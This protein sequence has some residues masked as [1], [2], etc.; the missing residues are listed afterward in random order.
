MSENLG[1]PDNMQIRAYVALDGVHYAILFKDGQI[2]R[3]G[4]TAPD[5]REALANG[6]LVEKGI[7]LRGPF[8]DQS[9]SP[10]TGSLLAVLCCGLGSSWP[11]MGRELYENF[12]LARAA[13][14]E[15]AE[16]ADWDIL[17][18]MAETGPEK[19]GLIRW[20][21]PYLFML[22]Y[23]QWRLFHGLGI[24][25][26]LVSGHSLGELVALCV[27]GVYDL[28]TAW[29]LMDTRA[30][31]MAELKARG[32]AQGGMLAV[33]ASWEDIS[34]VMAQWPGLRVANR[35]TVRQ[36][37]L[38]GPIAQLREARKQFRRA[39]I[40]AM[41]LNMDLAFHNPAMRILRDI[42]LFR[43]NSLPMRPP[44]F[45]VLSCVDAELY[46][47]QQPDICSRIADLDENAV[48]WVTSVE[49][50]CGDYGITHCL[51]LGPQETL[52]G[53]VVET[54]PNCSCLAADSKGHEARTM[55]E[56]LAALFAQGF[57][58]M[59]ALG[60]AAEAVPSAP[61][62][63]FSGDV[64]S[65]PA[66]DDV[67]AE[68]REIAVAL[69]AEA[70]HISPQAIRP[71]MDL[72]R[73]LGLRSSTFPFLVLEAE[74]RTGRQ[75]DME[76]LVPLAT[77]EDAIRFL[78]GTPPH[79]EPIASKSRT[80]GGK[81]R[82]P[83]LRYA[84]VDGR[85]APAPLDPAC[86]SAQARGLVFGCLKTPGL[87][88]GA[89]DV[90]DRFVSVES[91]GCQ[92]VR[93][94]QFAERIKNAGNANEAGMVL[95][96]PADC[97][98]AA[99][100]LSVCARFVSSLPALGWL[101]VIKKLPPAEAVSWLKDVADQLEGALFPWQAI[102]W[103]MEKGERLSGQEAADLLSNEL[104]Y[105]TERQIVWQKSNEANGS[106]FC[107][108][109][110]IFDLV[111][112][113]S[114]SERGVFEGNCQFSRFADPELATHGG[115]A[116]F[117][118]SRQALPETPF[119]D[120]PWLPLDRIVSVIGACAALV[121][122][123]AS[124]T[125][126][127]DVRVH[128]FPALPAGITRLGRVR[129]SARTRFPLY[130]IPTRLCSVRLEIAALTPSGR[131]NEEW[132][133]MA[134]AVCM[135][136]RDYPALEPL[137]AWPDNGFDVLPK[138]AAENF[139]AAL[140]F[141]PDWRIVSGFS[142]IGDDMAQAD[143]IV[144]KGCLNSSPVQRFLEGALQA[145]LLFNALPA[146]EAQPMAENMAAWRFSAIGLVRFCRS[147]D[148]ETARLHIRLSWQDGQLRR[149]EGQI[150]DSDHNLLLA[151]HNM[152]FDSVRRPGDK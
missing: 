120:D 87:V 100:M 74:Q 91:C 131:Q 25:P 104:L 121:A 56:T 145:A 72:R 122:G 86:D 39:K 150:V 98:H 127:A 43:L 82:T 29:Y 32:G 113:G 102:A 71:E 40:P 133:P 36:Y 79:A 115:S 1:F 66:L 35:N 47:S 129:A 93:M 51:E 97:A 99:T 68:N 23:A 101:V 110:R 80:F 53:L 78:T 88:Q 140:G 134:S 123:R 49:K 9:D 41:L 5:W 85:L 11:G 75:I 135:E 137:W 94:R 90:A 10:Q 12:P 42:S 7:W 19:T 60:R 2:W 37:I 96:L 84:L 61:A 107:P 26:A 128:R 48:D 139:Y 70:S 149:Y 124:L 24:T 13:M 148:A 46:P 28:P 143:L 76:T 67:S 52:C 55:R 73:D 50:M 116:I 14:D 118:P 109:S 44:R 130:Q 146:V 54:R 132:L 114:F 138:E 144:S 141:S 27:A 22:E 38:G 152:E 125:G 92:P 65:V 108:A 136:S 77:V 95:E 30:E 142:R 33:P 81:A 126:L 34:P 21:I 8:S 119:P 58:D 106:H 62:A 57:L 111:Y 17:G 15:I 69:L 6:E 63:Y 105:G 4:S 3:L 59:A 151:F 103:S 16:L 147:M 112:P 45:P 117:A 31:H 89:T 20:Q 18:L 64:Q 83:F